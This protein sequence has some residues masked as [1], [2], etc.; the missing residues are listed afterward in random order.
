MTKTQLIALYKA[1]EKRADRCASGYA[2]AG[3]LAFKLEDREALVSAMSQTNMNPRSAAIL[4]CS[5]HTDP[6]FS[7]TLGRLQTFHRQ[8]T[9]TALR[10]MP[11][12]DDGRVL[13]KQEVQPFD[14]RIK[15]KRD[16]QP[17][18]NRAAVQLIRVGITSPSD[19]LRFLTA[20]FEFAKVEQKLEQKTERLVQ[21]LQLGDL[22][23]EQVLTVL[24]KVKAKF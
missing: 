24:D 22:S 4:I 10:A 7:A 17:A 5:S 13:V 21:E 16:V 9:Q 1:A 8:V 2:G 12:I 23:R 11:A 18:F 20:G 19:A 15:S 14:G 3:G 6:K